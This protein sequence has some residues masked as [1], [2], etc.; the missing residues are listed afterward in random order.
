MIVAVLCT[1]FRCI[2][3]TVASTQENTNL[4][5]FHPTQLTLHTTHDSNE[6]APGTE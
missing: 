5:G 3:S 4:K 2:A 6:A 1:D